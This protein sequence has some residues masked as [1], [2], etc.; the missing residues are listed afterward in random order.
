MTIVNGGQYAASKSSKCTVSYTANNKHLFGGGLLGKNRFTIAESNAKWTVIYVVDTV[1]SILPWQAAFCCTLN[2]AV[3]CC[4][5]LLSMWGVRLALSMPCVDAPQGGNNTNVF[6]VE[7]TCS[8]RYLL[9]TLVAHR[10]FAA[11][12]CLGVVEPVEYD[13]CRRRHIHKKCST[14]DNNRT[15]RGGV[16][17]VLIGVALTQAVLVNCIEYLPKRAGASDGRGK[18]SLKIITKC[19]A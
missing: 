5:R 13:A 10:A 11:D 8:H 19:T 9:R 7:I 16:D 12:A 14:S 4:C 15:A 18:A 1:T 6:E 3:C 17:N 2:T